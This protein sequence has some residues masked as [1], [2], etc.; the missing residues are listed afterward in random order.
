MRTSARAALLGAALAALAPR[1]AA[2][3][4]HLSPAAET[5]LDEGLKRLY[6]LDY[7]QS[8]A[9]FRKL[10]ELE[11]DNPFG[12]LF[13]AG[14]IWWESSQ[15]FGLFRDTPTLQG[16]FEEDV[17]AAQRKADAYID[18][19]DP[20]LRADGYFVSGMAL[21]TLGQ[22][23]L[24]KGHWMEAYFAGKKAIKHL[25]KCLKLDPTYYDAD[26][27]LGVFD[28]QAAHLTGI[29]KLGFLVGVHG[30]EKRGL[31]EI[32]LAAEKSRYANRQAFE[33]LLCI[34]LIDL[35][36][37]S[38]ALPVV[39]KLRAD[40][41]ESPY[42]LF[43]EALLRHRLGDWDGSLAVGRQLY[44]QVAA[45]PA[46]FRAKWL[47]LV[48]G[49]SGADCLA[50]PDAEAA[51]AWF[52]HALETTAREKPAAFHALLHLFRGQL[53][54]SVGRR[55]EAAAEYRRTLALPDVDFAHRRAEECLSS[56]CPREEILAKLRSL[57]KGEPLDA[58]PGNV[59]VTHPR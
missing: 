59:I 32:R 44:A 9:A 42:Y 40:F 13:E 33:F 50:K 38:R 34:Y 28:Y 53:L 30:D 52:D 2:A 20:Q 56:P 25:K 46:A 10:I 48:C 12:Y 27:G 22:W 47:T 6:S 16:L 36:D 29:A 49:L 15:E 18:S 5:Q 58:S 54:D 19:K 39:Q 8:R 55:D 41:P 17:D 26:L 57:S 21:G 51:L 24:M 37:L 35:H 14:G 4:P 31:A 3:G 7:A 23:R 1:P 43:L 45:D 11:P